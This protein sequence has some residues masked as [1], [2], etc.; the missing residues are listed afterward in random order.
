MKLKLTK[1]YNHANVILSILEDISNFNNELEVHIYN[2]NI[3]FMYLQSHFSKSSLLWLPRLQATEGG[4]VG[5]LPKLKHNELPFPSLASD[6]PSANSNAAAKLLQ[7]WI[8][9]LYLK[10]SVETMDR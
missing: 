8:K 1:Y 5:R 7:A 2:L 9:I 10:G 3:T 6:C 4:G